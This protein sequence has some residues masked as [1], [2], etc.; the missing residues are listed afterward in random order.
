MIVFSTRDD[1]G[2]TTKHAAILVRV[3]RAEKRNRCVQS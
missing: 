2:G 1:T 3:S